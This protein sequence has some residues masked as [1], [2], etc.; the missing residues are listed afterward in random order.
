MDGRTTYRTLSPKRAPFQIGFDWWSH[1]RKV[2]RRRRISHT[3]PV[4]LWGC[5]SH[6]ISSPGPVFHG[7]KWLL[8]SPHIQSPTLHSRC[9]IKE[10]L[11]KRGSTIDHWRSRCKEWILWPTPYT[12]IH[13]YKHTY[14]HTYIHTIFFLYC[15]HTIWLHNRDFVSVRL[16]VSFF[17]LIYEFGCVIQCGYFYA[18]DVFLNTSHNSK[19]A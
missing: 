11:I 16:N 5:S 13:T 12:Y 15:Q 14:I 4:W 17:K 9:G 8:W 7:T 6:K 10:G 2:P 3:H 1:L 19:L 18:R